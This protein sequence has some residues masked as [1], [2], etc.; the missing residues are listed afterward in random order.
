MGEWVIKALLVGFAA[1]L[2]YH[3]L[4]P[5]YAFEIRI[6]SGRPTVRAGKVTPA[7]L[8][9]V[10]DAC[11]TGGVSRGWLGGIRYQTRTALRFSRD[12]PPGIR[13]RLRNEWLTTK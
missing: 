10:A 11:R 12:F 1:W 3:L 13:Q 5:R 6:T 9:S 2:I 7:F 8:D 4:R